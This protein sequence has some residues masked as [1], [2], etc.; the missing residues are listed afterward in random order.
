M[1]RRLCHHNG[2]LVIHEGLPAPDEAIGSFLWLD[3]AQ[4]S[5]AEFDLLKA[6]YGVDPN[7]RIA[8][9]VEE[10]EFLYMRARLVAPDDSQEP[11]FTPVQFVLGDTLLVTLHE[12]A[13]FMPFDLALMRLQRRPALAGDVRSL[14]WMLLRA[15]NDAADLAI[16]A[17]SATLAK[18]SEQITAISAGYG[19]SGREL[20]VSDL[21]ST[22][23][24]LNDTHDLI[25]DCLES[26]LSLTRLVR[27][28]G[29]EVDNQREAALQQL[30]NE[31]MGDVHSVKEHASFAHDKVRYLQGAVTSLLNIKQNQIVKV[32]TIITAVFL[33]PTL[34]ATFY[35]QNFHVMPELAWKYGFS[36]SLGLTLVSALLP[37]VYIK[38]KGWLR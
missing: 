30:V 14:L 25:S 21:T 26:Q 3:V 24:E 29:G 2:N 1:I 19:E 10:G 36:Y 16:E 31:L 38:R 33:P 32:F 8:S 27:H 9:F 37:L 28:L 6:R 35:G 23:L 11:C 34:V 17:V 7:A 4:A 13:R 15:A 20:G 5:A 22:L 18:T 12:S